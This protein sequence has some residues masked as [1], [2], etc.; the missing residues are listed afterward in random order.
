L[1]CVGELGTSAGLADLPE[2]VM[3]AVQRVVP[4]D[5]TF[6]TDVNTLTGCVTRLVTPAQVRLRDEDTLVAQYLH[7]HPVYAYAKRTGDDSA[8]TIAD[9]VSRSQWRRGPLYNEMY[10]PR[11]IEAQ[12]SFTF[13]TRPGH[14]IG[15][16]LNR[17]RP[18]F[19]ENERLLLNLLRPHLIEAYRNLEAT[20]R[21]RS[22][23][24]RAHAI[25]E[26]V[27][28]GI[29]AI[30]ANGRMELANAR[31]RQALALFF[32]AGTRGA[33]AL[34]DA[35]ERWL[36]HHGD[37]SDRSPVPRRPL[38]VERDGRQLNIRLVHDNGH[39]LLLLTERSTTIDLAPFIALGLTQ[40]EAEVLS[41]LAQGQTDGEI[42]T[43]IG[44]RP[45]TVGK[46]LERIYKKLGVET[47]T[48]A[49]ARAF[50]A[51]N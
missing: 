37:V 4:S 12:I 10:R 3:T 9:F 49:V 35:V 16:I 17:A 26:E 29:V 51:V 7:Q 23:L 38:V 22:A 20:A 15:V 13:S 8:H 14:T 27:G 36:R 31:A 30:G 48:A 42:G 25:I 41:W 50:D 5:S 40:R 11:G 43:I 2:A 24:A 33:D 28:F 21:T 18:E 19:R 34:P 46:H 45:K 6:W 44:S 39:V 32:G 47:R 1:D